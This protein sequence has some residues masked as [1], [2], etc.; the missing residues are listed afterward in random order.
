MVEKLVTR[1]FN[2]GWVVLKAFAGYDGLRKEEN[3][4][5]QI[6]I[7]RFIAE[8]RKAL[9]LTQAQ[10]AER[11]GVTDRAVSKWE[12]GRSMPD[13]S[14]MLDLCGILGITVNELLSG[15]YV[16]MTNYN[17]IAEENLVEMKR[18]EEE[19]AARLLKLEW[20]IGF[21]S[22][23]A[24]L[25][26]TFAAAALVEDKL[27]QGVLIVIGSIIFAVGISNSMKIEREAGY[28]ECPH[29]GHLYVPEVAPFWFSMHLGRTRYMKCPHCGK[30]GWQKK[31]LSKD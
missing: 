18:R 15:E 8:R 17:R 22:V 20:V 13:S 29:C 12:N 21:I 9:P 6:K 16:E 30:R 3:P 19:N 27:W 28:Y 2:R 26:L 14:L 10:L 5:D 11:L 25:T 7:G 31:V 24:F 23:A 4:M 1:R